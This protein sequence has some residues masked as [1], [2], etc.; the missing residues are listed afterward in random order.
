MIFRKDKSLYRSA[1]VLQPR[2]R[3]GGPG[4]HPQPA[5]PRALHAGR[6]GRP[7]RY[8][9]L[10]V[11]FVR[12]HLPPHLALPRSLVPPEKGKT[13]LIVK[14]HPLILKSAFLHFLDTPNLLPTLPKP[15]KKLKE[16]FHRKI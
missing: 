16:T 8:N 2:D 7:L 12:R 15:I 3:A 9:Q 5:L 4:L 10:Q 13:Y 11:H 6:E 14:H 1:G